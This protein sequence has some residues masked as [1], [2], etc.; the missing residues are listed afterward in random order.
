MLM[1][2]LPGSLVALGSH[3]GDFF[4]VRADALDV[5]QNY[6]RLSENAGAALPPVLSWSKVKWRRDLLGGSRFND[7]HHARGCLAWGFA[8]VV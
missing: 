8:G 1:H 4:Q 7:E 2:R 5:P 3:A 6:S